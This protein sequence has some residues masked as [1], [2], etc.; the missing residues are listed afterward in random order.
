LLLQECINIFDGTISGL[1]KYT[2]ISLFSPD[3]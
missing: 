1:V 2:I 3:S